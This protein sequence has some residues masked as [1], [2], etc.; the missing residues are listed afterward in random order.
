MISMAERVDQILLDADH[1]YPLI[2]D[3]GAKGKNF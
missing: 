3:N 2:P 1:H